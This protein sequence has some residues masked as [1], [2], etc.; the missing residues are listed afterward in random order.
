MRLFIAL[1]T[2]LLPVFNASADRPNIVFILI[3][4]LG[5]A[6]VSYQ[7]GTV[8]TPHI[9]RLA[10]EGIILDAHYVAPVCSPTRTGL[11]TG[12]CW[13]RFGV[14]TPTN[15]QALPFD[16][17]TMPRALKSA[18]YDTALAGKWHLGSLPEQGPNHFGFDHSYGSLAG[19]VGPYD[20]FYKQGPFS[21]TWHR[22]GKLLTEQGHVT[23]LIT[24]EACKWIS[25]RQANPFF[26]YLPYTAVH[27]PVKEP[28]ELLQRVPAGITDSVARHYAACLIH[29]DDSI[30]RIVAALES[31][32]KRSNT[33]IVFSSD[34]GGST[35]E[36]ADQNYPPDDYPKGRLPGNNQPYRGEKGSVYE[37]GIRVAAF[38]NWP[39][40]LKPT[41]LKT[42]VHIID[43]MP[44][45]CHLA[46]VIAPEDARWDGLNLW[47]HLTGGAPPAERPLYNVSPGWKSR[48]L[49]LGDWKLIEHQKS[50]DQPSYELYHLARDPAE[51]SDLSQQEPAILAKLQS[52]LKAISTTDRDRALP[53]FRK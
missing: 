18:G 25:E 2:C 43:W 22:N 10:K 16:T 42:P 15:D 33:L 28:E 11:M 27:L 4:D 45:F 9:D 1:L 38:A 47:P 52:A 5:R 8:S 13:S 37:G 39:G 30:G 44:T 53:K 36:N 20:H 21:T 26:L 49:H 17:F 6:D 51:T 48:A 19:G 3:D 50:K 29:L 34:N 12:R 24:D 35:A 40:K 46:G 23:D 32:G 41:V 7:G 31:A 14:T